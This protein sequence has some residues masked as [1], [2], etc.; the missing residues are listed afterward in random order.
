MPSLIAAA[1]PRTQSRHRGRY[2][3]APEFLHH[4]PAL[5]VRAAQHTLDVPDHPAYVLDTRM[6]QHARVEVLLRRLHPKIRLVIAAGRY[7]HGA[8]RLRAVL[9]QPYR[10]RVVDV[11]RWPN[12][13]AAYWRRLSHY[14]LCQ[15]S[16]KGV[17]HASNPAL[18]A[19]PNLMGWWVPAEDI[20]DR[21]YF[22]HVWLPALYAVPRHI[23][24]LDLPPRGADAA[25]EA[26]ACLQPS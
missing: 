11:R 19:D 8:E 26:L 5:L 17:P 13:E 24:V 20:L 9:P 12:D 23:V 21:S 18:L 22:R 2:P 16:M 10:E 6:A 25:I 4:F 7:P 3:Y 14:L 15:P 1:M